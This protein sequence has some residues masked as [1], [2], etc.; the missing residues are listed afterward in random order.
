MGQFI[1]IGVLR[2]MLSR[3][4]EWAYRIPFA[5]QW[6]W[7]IPLILGVYFAPESP[8]WLVR[9]DRAEE[10]CESV[11]RLT[12]K[13]D[14]NF[15]PERSVA[16]M[17]HTNEMEKKVSEGTT[18]WDCFKSIDLRRTEICC[19][20]WAIQNLCG[21]AFMG[22]STYFYEQAGLSVDQAFSLSL[23]QFGLGAVGTIVSWFLI[24]YFG[25]RTLYV[26]GLAV[27]NTLLFI[28][29][30]LAL[31]PSSNKGASWGIGSMLLVFTLVY[32][33]TVGPVLYSLVSEL[34]STRL[35]SKTIVLA[36][37]TYLVTG[38]VNGIITP[39]MLNPTAWNW[40]GKA[41]FF[42]AGICSLCV[43]WTYFRLPEPKGRTYGELD[44]LFERQIS[45][46]KFSS[47]A[48]DP[49]DG[50]ISEFDTNKPTIEFL[51][52]ASQAN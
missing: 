24:T 48:V 3:S 8:W 33:S 28:T 35:R 44:V 22:Y 41:G 23:G 16:L 4:D 6:I 10:A 15:N 42:W 39:Y 47:T 25:R 12:S 31:A 17:I 20:I 52:K 34:P 40:R 14:P 2:G 32:D 27:M 30:F 49:F 50:H 51:E 38:I 19:V 43:I 9:R 37:N 11:R 7:P 13:V 5:I 46:R 45:A 18:Y 26:T 29:G 21:S 1:G 36:R